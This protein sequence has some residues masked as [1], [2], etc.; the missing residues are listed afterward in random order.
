M[1]RC[2]H[3]RL[4]RQDILDI[5]THIAQEDADAADRLLDALGE[6]CGLLA[7]TPRLG[8]ARP[9]LAPDLRHSVL[10]NLLI[11]Y[12]EISGG[13]EIVRVLHARRDLTALF[14]PQE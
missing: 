2:L 1:R 3:T 10:G 5:W 12:R 14:S 9:D 13:V 7:A 4:A 8:P 11:L 6:R